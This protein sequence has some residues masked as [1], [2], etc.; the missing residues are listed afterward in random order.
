MTTN[1]AA[2]TIII[3][4]GQVLGVN[5]LPGASTTIGK[6]VLVSLVTAFAVGAVPGY[7]GG[8]L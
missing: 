1:T 4:L 5:L 3:A 2:L 6:V 7:I 8:L